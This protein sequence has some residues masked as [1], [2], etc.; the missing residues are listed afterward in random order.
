MSIDFLTEDNY[1]QKLGK[2]KYICLFANGSPA[3]WAMRAGKKEGSLGEG[4]FARTLPL[5]WWAG[6][7]LIR[8]IVSAQNRFDHRSGIVTRGGGI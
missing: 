4:I 7:L 8:V 5:G 2:S 1:N 6:L 3:K